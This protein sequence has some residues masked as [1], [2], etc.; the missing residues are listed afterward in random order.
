MTQ[1]S[2]KELLMENAKK[3]LAKTPALPALP[4]SRDELLY[5]L[6]VH[7]I[8]LEIQNEELRIAQSALQESHDRYLNLYEFSPI[9]YLTLTGEGL[10]AEINL[11]G[12]RIL[13]VERHKLINQC[14]AGLIMPKDRDYW[15][16]Q[17][18]RLI[19]YE[20]VDSLELSFQRSDHSLCHARLNCLLVTPNDKDQLVRINFTDITENKQL[21]EA[22]GLLQKITSRIP[23]VVYQFCLRPDGSSYFPYASEGIKDIFRLNPEDVYENAAKA[24]ALI[25][26]EDY[27]M[28]VASIAQSAQNLMPWKHECRVRFDDGTV[29]WLLGNAM[30]ER[31]ADNSTLWHG[32]ISDIT[33]R[34]IL[35]QKLL[36]LSQLNISIVDSL[37]SHIAVLDAQGDIIAVNKAW[38]EFGKE[39]NLPKNCQSGKECHY[40]N[41]CH[42]YD[43]ISQTDDYSDNTARTGITAVLAGE[44]AA[45][46][47]EYT[48]HIRNQQFWYH[49]SV[50]P[51]QSS[52]G[53]VVI[54]HKNITERKQMKKA[55]SDSEFRWKFALEG[56]GDGVWDRNIQ[57]HQ[58]SYS[59]QWKEMLGYTENEILPTHKEWLKRIHPDDQLSVTEALQAYLEG[60]TLIYSIEYR[61]RCKDE[62]YKWIL[63]R[64]MLVSRSE[65]GKPLRIIGTNTDI[66]VIKQIQITLQ[67]KEQMLCHSQRIAHIG[68]WALNLATGYLNWSDEMYLIFGVSP[69]TFK[70]NRAALNDLILAEDQAL[71][72]SWFSDCLKGVAMHELVFR[73]RLPDGQTRFISSNGELQYD[74]MNKPLCLVGSSQDI[75]VR[76]NREQQDRE[77]LNQLAHVTRLG[78]MGEMAS[79][80]A[81][82]V[83]QPLTAIAT[84]AQVSLNLMQNEN[85]DLTK[86]A[87]VIYKTQQQALRA[88]QI[89]HRMRDFIKPNTQQMITTHL[90]TV[91]NNAAN[92][93]LPE[94]IHKE[95]SL[96]LELQENLPPVTID[97]I[98]I[99]QVII[100]LIRN[101]AD[102]LEN[103]PKNQPRKLSI[104]SWLTLDNTLEVRIKDNGPGIDEDQRQKVL[105]PFYT[106]KAEGMGMG[107]SISQSIIGA[108]NG[109]LYFNSKLGKGCT[110]YFTLPVSLPA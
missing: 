17:F 68:S 57:N 102:A 95:I 37:D 80:I 78:L 1:L 110:F 103:C 106:T 96:S 41:D 79:G 83:N 94:L 75:T 18:M 38:R 72:K 88:G 3:R 98:Q 25:H 27:D 59:R 24:F 65:D 70:H 31:K 66:S 97:A 43:L 14:F 47:V 101:S 76:K 49:M 93:C 51:L 63:S 30:P 39:N 54:S 34:K 26:P 9:G 12:V 77:H 100:N 104:Q 7:Q 105:M 23:G 73:I 35:E 15:H 90:N 19:Q 36:K 55:L 50:L 91:I 5:N 99:E 61:L 11:T 40:M 44:L 64:G 42:Y 109:T 58:T 4:D 2:T 62:S 32:F 85:P 8:E 107:L 87:E 6:Q 108:H 81:H 10:I 29:R 67:E 92:L 46:N 69:E 28:T 20:P 53:G 82:E 48:V 16:I 13:G 33:E 86:L 21:K 22:L 74:A 60:K 56:C 45:F 84:Y 71:R 52:Q 89:I